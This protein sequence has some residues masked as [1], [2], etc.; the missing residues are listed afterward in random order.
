MKNVLN[1]EEEK[2]ELNLLVKID[3]LLK[4]FDEIDEII[5]ELPDKQSYIELLRSDLEHLLEE[6]EMGS[7]GYKNIAK[8][9]ERVRKQR[10]H[11][12][13]AYEIIK[14]FQLNRNKI[15]Y[16]E[17][18]PFVRNAL[19]TVFKELQTSY[20]Y[21]LLNAENIK[22]LLGNEK[23]N[24]EE[25]KVAG[26]KKRT[27]FTAT[28]E[29][30]EEDIKNGLTVED[31]LKKY[32]VARSTLFKNFKEMGISYYKTKKSNTVIGESLN[33]KP[34]DVTIEM[35]NELLEKGYNNKQMAKYWGVS[36]TS[37]NLIKQR[38]GVAKRSYNYKNK[39]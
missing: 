35:Y 12:K 21:R 39:K 23:H 19:E 6:K 2:T 31:I 33:I 8:E 9:L 24:Q 10:R 13:K 20:N 4:L 5:K 37:I 27:K 30:L 25:N 26:R 14:C 38:L 3:Q 28:K 18:R 7:V 32:N 36:V 1:F 22:E 34:K 15:A 29:E 11:L 16:K 17:Q